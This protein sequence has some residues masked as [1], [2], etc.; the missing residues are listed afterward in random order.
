MTSFSYSSHKNARIHIDTRVLL[1]QV[2]TLD[3]V[4]RK[5]LTWN[6]YGRK[7][8]RNFQPL[9]TTGDAADND[10][11]PPATPGFF[12]WERAK[13]LIHAVMASR[14]P[15]YDPIRKRLENLQNPSTHT[16]LSILGLWLA[17]ELKISVSATQPMVAAMLY[18]VED[19]S[20]NWEIL[21]QR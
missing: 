18:A 7:I 17:G 11:E 5:H 12:L 4:K 15:S 3:H 20:G 10:M 2:A 16:L 6:E 9:P 8:A 14:D 13:D 19:A 21:Q 1:R